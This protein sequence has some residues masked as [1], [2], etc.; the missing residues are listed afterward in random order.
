MFPYTAAATMMIA[1]YPPW[2]LEGGVDKLIERCNSPSPSA[3]AR[4]IEHR[5]PSWPPWQ[6]EASRTIS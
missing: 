1:I 3:H 6:A 2:S 5:I 4:D